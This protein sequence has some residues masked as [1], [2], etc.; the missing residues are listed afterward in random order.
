[1]RLCTIA[2]SKKIYLF[3]SAFFSVLSSVLTLAPYVAV[4]III[5]KILE[6][7]F[8]SEG[9]SYI[10][11]TGLLALLCTVLRF[12][13]LFISIMLSH[14]AAFN[15]LYNLRVSLT[16][17]LG[18]LNMGFFT[19]NQT[20]K[21]KKVLYEDIEEVEIFVAHHIPDIVSG[22]AIPLIIIAYLFSVDVYMALVSLIPLPIAFVMQQK[23]FDKKGM[24]ERRKNYHDALENLNGTI[25]EYVRGMPVVKVFNFSVESFS[26][27]KDAAMS[28]MKFIKEI[29]INQ[30][31]P[32]A[33]F[34]SITSSGLFFII[35]F[36]FYFYM[37][38]MI[39]L[40]V[41][42]LFLML[43][44]GYM[45]PLFRL[46][47]LGGQLGH[48]FEGVKRA[49]E[50]LETPPV[51]EPEAGRLPFC[52]DIEFKNVSFG[53]GEKNVLENV[54]FKTGEGEMCALVGPSGAGKT[55][56]AHLVFR[57]WDI[58]EGEILIGGV[59]IKDITR[60]DLMDSIGA[61]FQDTFIFSDTVYENITM[62]MKNVSLKDVE[63]AAET[64]QC[65]GFI[66]KLPNGF[67]TI[68]GEGG[69]VHLSGG[70]KQR[71]ALARIA[72]KNPPIII[73]DEATAY[74][75]AENEA[76]IQEAFSSIIKD[77]T[78]LIIAHR[79]STIADSDQILVV[80]NGSVEER[81]KHD[82]LISNKGIYNQMWQAHIDAKGWTISV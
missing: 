37:K 33:V 79:L 3:A 82:E 73:L 44:S 65:L 63:K 70:E 38:G 45:T 36:G 49:D 72:L 9:Y 59:N 24:E 30:A 12:V 56:I 34:V 27:L 19:G 2:G 62:G 18:R 60:K 16:N 66:E 68:I 25:V 74:T 80:K 75:D 76:K 48:I 40:S 17:H 22:F 15:I 58:S 61:V 57:M 41:Y 26:R 46:A 32:W 28:Y 20:G 6:P 55:T 52:H 64:A 7:G 13:F 4:Y 71:I 81:G 1:M 31:P 21:I 35:P 54:S 5:T 51:K 69:E 23:A 47:M 14:I 11:K 78:V 43:G 8:D 42:L 67:D 39:S 10:F 53:Y 29:T 77:K 50:I